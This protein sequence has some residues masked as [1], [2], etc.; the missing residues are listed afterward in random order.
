MRGVSSAFLY[1]AAFV[2]HAKEPSGTEPLA[3]PTAE[4]RAANPFCGDEVE[5]AVR[6]DEGRIR[7]VAHRGRSCAIVT[8]SSSLIAE[9]VRGRTSSEVRE[10]AAQLRGALA[11]GSPFPTRFAALGPVRL[12]PS[13]HRCALLP[14]E[15]L[16]NALDAR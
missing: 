9:S 8:V 3:E 13:R 7:A 11:N 2:A 10:L 16:L 15:A 4:G 14:W 5:V 1:D 6:I 12:L